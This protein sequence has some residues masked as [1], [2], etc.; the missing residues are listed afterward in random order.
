[1]EKK[2]LRFNLSFFAIACLG[3]VDI[4]LQ[5]VKTQ[6]NFLQVSVQLRATFLIRPGPLFKKS[7]G[8]YY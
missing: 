4:K 8:F 6:K 1:M 7:T 3:E 5:L 2:Q